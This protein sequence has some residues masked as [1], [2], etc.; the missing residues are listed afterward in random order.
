MTTTDERPSPAGDQGPGG[1]NAVTT[2]V[3]DLDVV[4]PVFNEQEQLVRSV[5]T[6]HAYLSTLP[7]SFRITIAD[8]ASTDD[9]PILATLLAE[10]LDRVQSLVIN[11]KGRGFALKQAWSH[12]D[13]RVLVYMDVDLSTDLKALPPLVAPL[14]S[15]HSDLAIGTRLTRSSH[16]VRG[17]K[18]EVISRCYNTLLRGALRAKFSDA[19]CGFKA[20][21][22]DVA[23]QLLPLV[24]DDQWFFDTELLVLAERAGLRIHEVPVDW[25]DDPDSRVDIVQTAVDDLRGMWRVG[26]GLARGTIPLSQVTDRLGRTAQVSARGGLHAQV[27]IFAVIGVVST[28]AYAILFL[29][30]RGTVG[31]QPANLLAL[32]ITAVANTAANRHYTFGIRGQEQLGRHHVQGLMVFAAGLAATSGVLALFHAAAGYDH[33]AAEMVL[34]TC[35]NLGV[36]VVR[37]VSMRWWIFRPGQA[38]EG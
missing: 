10:R 27:V 21:R 12:S 7:Y 35:A 17:P 38:T 26:R 11:R 32:V 19:Q 18:R 9:T 29:L 13:A 23:R 16:T 6:L 20:I 5:E 15:G 4:I 33:P 8:N 14:L 25:I 3:L 1:S 28:L 24:E 34:L 36:T 37:F 31:P 30:L 22:G 2:R